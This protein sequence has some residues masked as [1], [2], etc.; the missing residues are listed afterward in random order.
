[1]A[2]PAGKGRM[3]GLE[4]LAS[5][6]KGR[7]TYSVAYTLSKNMRAFKTLNRGRKFPFKYDRRHELSTYFAY[8]TISQKKYRDNMDIQFRHPGYHANTMV[9]GDR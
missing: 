5:K 1:M 7:L 6:N 8:H 3:N 2:E 9:S 4:L